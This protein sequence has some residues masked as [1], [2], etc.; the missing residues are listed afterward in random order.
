MWAK[1]RDALN[2]AGLKRI[3]YTGAFDG[4]DWATQCFIE[5]P[6]P[7]TGIVKS[8]FHVIWPDGN[9]QP[10]GLNEKRED[11]AAVLYTPRMGPSTGTSADGREIILE[12]ADKEQWLPLRVGAKVRARVKA[13]R[14]AAQKMKPAS[15]TPDTAE[16]AATSASVAGGGN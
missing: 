8:L 3:I 2:L 5:A 4:P 12:V 10:F 9:T 6:S 16:S 11:D 13:V 14:D 15:G 7:R 1:I